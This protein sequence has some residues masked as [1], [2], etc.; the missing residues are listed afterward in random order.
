MNIASYI[1]HTILKPDATK[2]QVNKICEEAKEYNFASVC[3]NAFRTK[4]VKE[5]LQGSHVKV[6]TVVGF[7]LGAVPTEVKVFETNLAIKHGANEIDMVINIGA[8]KDKDYDYVYEDIKGVVD[9]CKNKALV[10]VIIETCLL[11]DEEKVKVCELSVKAG[12]EFVKTSTGFSKG[13][14]TVEDVSLMKKTVEENA[15]VKASGGIR[16]YE[17]AKAVIDAGTDRIGASA[18]IAI[19][20]GSK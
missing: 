3:V 13:G 14:A 15:K 18:G 10:K 20:E 6:C 7:P 16:D 2:E 19:V 4:L 1:D 17:T 5:Q 12:A 11:T 9:A 8:L